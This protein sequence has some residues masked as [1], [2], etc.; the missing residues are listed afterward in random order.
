MNVSTIFET[1]KLKTG[2]FDLVPVQS[3]VKGTANRDVEIKLREGL[4]AK[5]SLSAFCVSLFMGLVKCKVHV[6]NIVP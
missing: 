4:G 5:R 1:K 2:L 6:Y 3:G